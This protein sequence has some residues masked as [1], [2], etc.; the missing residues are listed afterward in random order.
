MLNKKIITKVFLN[1]REFFEWVVRQ[2]LGYSQ[3]NEVIFD[4]NNEEGLAGHV[5]FE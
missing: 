5:A 3:G 2:Q 4:F 1:D